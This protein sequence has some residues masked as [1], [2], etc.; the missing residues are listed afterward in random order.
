MPWVPKKC[1]LVP[2]DFS[3]HSHRAIDL[4]LE[5]C[6]RPEHVHVFHVLPIMMPSDPGMVWSMVE[7]SERIAHAKTALQSELNDPKYAGI[8]HEVVVGDPGTACTDRAEDLE[9]DLIILPSHGRTGFTRFLLGSVAE[10]IVRMAK[11]PVLVIKL[12]E[13]PAA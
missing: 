7:D 9:A 11:C 10:R 1:V 5:I 2:Y 4:A 12:E 8:Q 13:N 3:D 6:D